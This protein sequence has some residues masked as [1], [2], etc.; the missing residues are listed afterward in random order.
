LGVD[1]LEVYYA[2]KNPEIWIPSP[3]VTEKAEELAEAY[4]LLKTCGTDSHG[5]SILRRI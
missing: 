5:P 4:G 3:E 2:Y 1:G